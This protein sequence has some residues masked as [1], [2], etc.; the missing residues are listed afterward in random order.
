MIL[1]LPDHGWKRRFAFLPFTLP[2]GPTKTLVWWEPY[3]SR[4]AGLYTEVSL[5]NP[6]P[7]SSEPADAR[8]HW[9]H[10]LSATEAPKHLPT[11]LPEKKT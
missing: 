5:E 3:W 8:E 1:E 10:P 9:S 2:N 4:N 11:P 6:L 7:T